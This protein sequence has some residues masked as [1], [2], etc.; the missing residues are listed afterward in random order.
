[1]SRMGHKMVC[2]RIYSWPIHGLRVFERGLIPSYSLQPTDT[3]MQLALH[4]P[5]KKREK[6]HANHG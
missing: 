3:H 1:M 5:K 2:R 4:L 6:V